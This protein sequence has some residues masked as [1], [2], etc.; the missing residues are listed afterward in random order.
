MR[1]LVLDFRFSWLW[2]FCSLFYDAFSVTRLYSADDRAT[3]EWWWIN[4]DKHPCLK[5]DS[6]LQSQ[7]L[8]DQGLRPLGVAQNH[9]C[10]DDDWLFWIVTPGYHATADIWVTGFTSLPV[11]WLK[12]LVAGFTPRRSGFAPMSVHVGIV[13]DKVSLERFLFPSSSVAAVQRHSLTQSTW[14]TWVGTSRFT[15]TLGDRLYSTYRF[16]QRKHATLSTIVH[17]DNAASPQ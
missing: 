16:Q 2:I 8:S 6:N 7:L 10:E 9:S 13:V 1:I 5:R 14:T 3:R 11:T 15:R 4:E 12:R 17:G